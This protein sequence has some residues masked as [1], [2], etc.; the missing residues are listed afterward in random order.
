MDLEE[1]REGG[2]EKSEKI[3]GFTL[4]FR[5]LSVWLLFSVFMRSGAGD[6]ENAACVRARV[7]V[8]VFATCFDCKLD[9]ACAHCDLRL[10]KIDRRICLEQHLR[11]GSPAPCL[12][13]GKVQRMGEWVWTSTNHYHPHLQTIPAR[14]QKGRGDTEQLRGLWKPSV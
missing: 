2:G 10:R 5:F 1:G 12:G 4:M 6:P 13:S 8:C 11:G 9:C 3:R 14:P 7:C